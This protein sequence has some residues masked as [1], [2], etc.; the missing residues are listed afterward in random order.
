ND[1]PIRK[2][3][4]TEVKPFSVAE[5]AYWQQYGIKPDTLERYNV[6]SLKSFE[7]YNRS[8][9]IYK[10]SSSATE[11]MF[12]YMGMGFT[13]VYRPRNQNMRFF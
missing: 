10:I 1:N 8:N 11:P 2:D 3:Y 7:G 12:A 13:K 5:L 4:H 6:H 9:K